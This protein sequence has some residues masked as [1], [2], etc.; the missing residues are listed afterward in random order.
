MLHKHEESS[1]YR[2]FMPPLVGTPAE[3]DALA[4][5]LNHLVHGR[6][7]VALASPQK[8]SRSSIE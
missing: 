6:E 2:A 7:Q 8:S 3:R 4:D 1:P 5:Y